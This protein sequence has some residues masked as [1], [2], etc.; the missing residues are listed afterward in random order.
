M[1]S[2]EPTVKLAPLSEKEA[3]IIVSIMAEQ[4]EFLAPNSRDALLELLKSQGENRL[5]LAEKFL[6][7]DPVGLAPFILAT[8]S[9]CSSSQQL[10]HLTSAVEQARSNV[11]NGDPFSFGQRF[12]VWALLRLASLYVGLGKN[13]N[14]IEVLEKSNFDELEFLSQNELDDCRFT[15]VCYLVLE[16]ENEKARKVLDGEPVPTMEWY[17]LNALLRF[18][19]LGDT[20]DSRGAL[21]IAFGEGVSVGRLLAGEES[22]PQAESDF[23]DHIPAKFV[24]EYVS[25]TKEAWAAT[26]GAISWIQDHLTKRPTRIG[27]QSDIDDVR[28]MRCMKEFELG[29]SHLQRNNHK[30]AK[31][32]FNQALRESERLN[33]GGE[34]FA[35]IVELISDIRHRNNES[36]SDLIERL[37]ARLKSFQRYTGDPSPLFF[38][39]SDMGDLFLKLDE[40]SRAETCAKEALTLWQKHAAEMNIDTFSVSN[41]YSL[42]ASTASLMHKFSEAKEYLQ[43]HIELGSR[44]LGPNHIGLVESLQALRYAL[45]NL[46]EHEKELEVA[47]RA[48]AIDEFADESDEVEDFEWCE[49]KVLAGTAG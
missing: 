15:L 21:S 44:Y 45:H 19:E 3:G 31:R 40:H 38:S 4:A 30:D 43:Q 6:K 17:Y 48:L 7:D 33:D 37:D 25:L 35:S 20:A 26:D 32:S 9:D 49:P 42:L 11:E 16:N 1:P 27:E 13:S 8:E 22:L 2:S 47:T 12:L 46:G 23:I 29:L 18:R 10:A 14:A 41:M 34:F 24:Y 39:F 5:L 28:L 36:V